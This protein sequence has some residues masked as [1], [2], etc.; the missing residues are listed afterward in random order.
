M[1]VTNPV[2]PSPPWKNVA[3]AV[4]G[5]VAA[6]AGTV[7]FRVHAVGTGPVADLA[8]R[9]ASATVEAV[10][11]D[12]PR[13]VKQRTGEFRRVS[14]VVPA[15][16]EAVETFAGRVRTRVPVVLFASGSSG[17]RSCPASASRSG[18]VRA[19]ETG[20][21]LAAVIMVREPPRVLSG[22]SWVQRAAETL[23]AGLR[24]A[25]DALPGPARPAARP[26]RR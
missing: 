15:R 1:T 26:G 12:D 22:P 13:E 3:V 16:I 23:R 9:N 7:A 25:A 24:E 4:L 21:L 20:E 11:T 17:G 10:L 19:A 8:G 6:V 2:R 18:A 5:C 14:F